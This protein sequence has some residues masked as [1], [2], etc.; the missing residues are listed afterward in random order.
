MGN[1]DIS[2]KGVGIHH[3]GREDDAEQM[4]AEFVKALKGK[5]HSISSAVMT[6]GGA[7]DLQE[8]EKLLPVK[9]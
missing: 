1:W 4:A 7:V 9:K 5:G 8:P 3:N 6:Y 2:I